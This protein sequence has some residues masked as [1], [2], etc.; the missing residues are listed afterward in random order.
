VVGF[1]G[2]HVSVWE[3]EQKLLLDHSHVIG[4]GAQPMD[5]H[6][7]AVAFVRFQVGTFASFQDVFYDDRMGVVY[8]SL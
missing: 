6:D 4:C 7:H 3:P 5:Q 8:E 1:T 2:Y